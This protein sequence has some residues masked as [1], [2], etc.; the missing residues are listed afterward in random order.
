MQESED[1]KLRFDG[2]KRLYGT[3][4]QILA[5]SRVA[6]IGLGGVGS[7]SGEALARTGVG[8]ISLYDLDDI[9]LSNINRQLPALTQNVGKAKISVMGERIKQI[10]PNC[11]VEEHLTWVLPRNI[12]DL[13]K[14]KFDFII[15]ACDSLK[16]KVALS[17]WCK[18]NKV[19]F[20]S[21]GSAGGKTDA[22]K[23]QILDLADAIQDPLL[24][25]LRDDLRKNHNFP[26]G[27]KKMGIKVV[28]SSQQM[29]RPKDCEMSSTKLDCGG[30]FGSSVIVTG[31]FGFAAAGFA[32]DYLLNKKT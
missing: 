1:Y 31:T 10:N 30:G 13:F 2:T 25:R 3:K 23:I 15:D 5:K 32:I 21:S 26:K 28:T 7:W 16:T 17:V 29:I 8:S 14:D 4:S 6:L 18:R 27:G 20:I 11:N 12:E 19:G 24:A 9:C 22:T